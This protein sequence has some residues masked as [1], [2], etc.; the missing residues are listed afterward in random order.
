MHSIQNARSGRGPLSVRAAGHDWAILGGMAGRPISPKREAEPNAHQV[1][2]HTKGNK[3]GPQAR[4]GMIAPGN[5]DLRHT[6][7]PVYGEPQ[8]LDIEH[9]ALDHRS[10]EQI[11]GRFP[12]DRT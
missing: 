6:V 4:P 5:G 12:G 3:R 10:T 9:P 7:S 1:A 11:L 2:Q 8:H